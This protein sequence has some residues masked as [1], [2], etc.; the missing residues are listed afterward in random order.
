[1]HSVHF[2]DIFKEDKLRVKCNNCNHIYS[3]RNPT[4]PT[5]KNLYFRCKKCSQKVLINSKSTI[6]NTNKTSA[7]IEYNQS[8]KIGNIVNIN[9]L[10][11][12]GYYFL[13]ICFLP[14]IAT[15]LL[16]I[17]YSYT[18]Y[19]EIPLNKK[20]ILI[21][22]YIK[23][24]FPPNYEI[25]IKTADLFGLGEKYYIAYGNNKELNMPS[26]YQEV[27]NKY[28]NYL[29]TGLPQIR[30]YHEKHL[31][32]F[33]LIFKDFFFINFQSKMLEFTLDETF[34]FK[35]K[36]IGGYN[37][38][39]IKTSHIDWENG[40]KETGI[41]SLMKLDVIDLDNDK[42]DEIVSEWIFY[43][44]GQTA[45]RFSAIIEFVDNEIKVNNGYPGI[46][47]FQISEVMW[48]YLRLMGETIHK[49]K[50]DDNLPIDGTISELENLLGRKTNRDLLYFIILNLFKYEKKD[51]KRKIKEAIDWNST[52]FMDSVMTSLV[53]EVSLEQQILRTIGLDEWKQTKIQAKIE[54]K[55]GHE[56]R[57]HMDKIMTLIDSDQDLIKRLE[58]LTSNINE[59]PY[60]Y[61][62]FEYGDNEVAYL[63]K[64]VFPNHYA[65]F[66]KLKKDLTV[67]VD[68]L[69]T[70]DFGCRQCKH[71]WRIFGYRYKD[72]VWISDRNI[73]GDFAN[74]IWLGDKSSKGY[75]FHEIHGTYYKSVSGFGLSEDYFFF[76][77]WRE[78][79]SDAYGSS[80]HTISPVEKKITKIYTY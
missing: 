18:K 68:A 33:S 21:D 27:I 62:A 59:T 73:N 78:P 19:N 44:F 75:T 50:I 49:Q 8:D 58:I 16:Y 5:D 57:M 48:T 79:V 9:Y 10:I 38:D 54:R 76:S 40:F 3:V 45:V 25:N 26:K 61:Y 4:I 46:F 43:R 41:F 71:F 35:P 64:R 65:K 51:D 30:I 39:L 11:S 72:G 55:Y 23:S 63:C 17:G 56:F 53:G 15:Y 2:D 7:S 67:F 80:M 47:N 29:D 52:K 14:A 12:R 24:K 6:N 37:N 36:I 32:F 1:V 13:K 20:D 66:I 28:H 77:D 22:L 60:K 42:K 74:G 31:D 34:I 69:P 70:V